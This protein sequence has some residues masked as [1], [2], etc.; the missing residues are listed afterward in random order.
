MDKGDIIQK[1]KNFPSKRNVDKF[2]AAIF[3]N[4]RNFLFMR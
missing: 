2:T 1:A 4:S 3:C